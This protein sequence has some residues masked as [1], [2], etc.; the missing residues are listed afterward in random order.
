MLADEDGFAGPGGW[1]TIRFADVTGD[2]KADLCARS[3]KGFACWPATGGGFG[4]AIAGPELSDAVGWGGID[5]WSTIRMGD[6]N[7]DGRADV[8]ARA[9][10]GM[11]CWLS[12]GKGFPPKVDGP[13]WSD[14]A[15]WNAPERYSS[16]RLGDLDGDGK[17][18]LCARAA[19]GIVCSRFDGAAFGPEIDG[20][21]LSDASGWDDESNGTTLRF[22]DVTGDGKDDVCVRGNAGVTCWPSTGAGFGKSFPGP[23][24]SDEGGWWPAWHHRTIRA[25]DLDGD[26]K[27]DLCARGASGMHCYKST[28]EGFGPRID[29]PAWSSAVGWNGAPYYET[30]LFAGEKPQPK[31]EPEPEPDAGVVGDAAIP[32]DASI[33]ED[34]GVI[35]PDAAV[36]SADPTAEDLQGGCACRAPSGRPSGDGLVLVGAA[37]AIAGVCRRRRR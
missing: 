25:G 30:I 33:V 37:L 26:G 4:A 20:P 2:G 14:A 6:L 23:E 1:S 24:W 17:L 16:I 9:G 5:H 29:G 21:G 8:C 11:W 31:P 36:P 22:V 3:S 15:G 27:L 34:G 28:G 10:A 35:E 18:D 7:G 32:D 13:A 19:K 12:D